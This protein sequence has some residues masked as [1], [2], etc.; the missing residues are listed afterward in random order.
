MRTHPAPE[1]GGFNPRAF[2]AFILCSAG[3]LLAMATFAADPPTGTLTPAN[4]TLTY[5]AGPFVQANQ[6]PLALGQLDP[7]PR[8]DNTT[9]PCDSYVL[10]VSLPAGYAATHPNAAARVTM[11]WTDTG[12]GQSDY[13][14]YIF[15][16]DVGDLDG[17]RQ[18]DYQSASGADPEVAY[19]GPIPDGQSKYTIKIVPY[20]PTGETVNVKIEFLPGNGD[21]GSPTFGSADPTKPGVPRY[22]NFY[23]PDGSSAESSQG[24]F[25]IGFN[26]HTGRMM[27]MNT[28]PIWRITPPEKQSPAKPECCEGLWEDVTAP[29][30]ETG[31]DPILWTDQVSGRTFASNSTV[32]TNGVYA[33]SDNDGDLWNPVTAAPPNASSDHETIGSGPYPA[34]VPL[35]NPANQG[36][37]VY[38]CAQTFPV[39]AAACQRSDTLGSDYGPS[40][41]PY[42]AHTSECSGIHGHVRVGPDGT[43]YLPVRDCGGNAG[44]AVSMDAGT[45]WTNYI[46]PNSKTQTH[47]SDPSVAIGANNTVYFF[48]VRDQ[49]PSAQD[50]IEGHIHVQVST[51]HGATWGKD[52]D[53]G[54]SHGIRNAVFPEAWAG[55][56]ARAAVGFLGTNRPGDYEGISFPGLWYAFIA[57]TFDSGTTWNIVNATPN[58]PVQGVGGIWQGGGSPHNRNLLDFN[59]ATADDKGRFLYGYSDGCVGNCVQD[60]VQN[61]FTAFMRVARQSGG[62][63]LFAA[64]DV[65]EPHPANPACLSGTRGRD[66]SHLTWIAPDNGGADI[67]SYQIFRGTT[68]NFNPVV[69]IAETGGGKT[70]YFDA[71]AD[72][73]VEHYFYVIK[74]INSTGIGQRSNTID[75]KVVPVPPLENVCSLAGITILTDNAGDS[76]LTPSS[77]GTDMLAAH[78]SQPFVQDGVLKFVFTMDTDPGTDTQPPGSGWFIAM[79][80]PDAQAQGGFRYTGVRMDGGTTPT[81]ASYTPGANTSGGVD[82]RFVDAEKP[83]EP[84]SHYDSANGKIVIVV[85]ASDLGLKPGDTIAGFVSGSSQSTDPGPIGAGATEVYDFMPDSGAFTGGYTVAPNAA[86]APNTPPV[87]VLTASPESGAA[88]LNVSFSG[89]GSSDADKA[90]KDTIVSYTFNF[91]DGSAP[92]TQSSPTISHTYKAAGA[93]A[94]QL[95]VKD[96]RGQE[97][98]N[99]AR[100]I[101]EVN[102]ALRNIS[103]RADVKT[104][105]NVLIGGFIISGNKSRTVVLRAIG[106]SLESGGNPVGGRMDDPLLELHAA[107]GGII[108]TN[109]NWKTNDQTHTSQEAQVRNTGLAP[110][111]N[112]ESVIVRTLPPGHYTAILRGKNNSTGIALVE[113]YDIDPA[114]TSKL[115]NISTRGLVETGDNVMI[116]GFVAGPE[117]AAPTDVLLRGLGPSLSDRHVANALQDPVLELRDSNGTMRASNDNWKSTQQAEIQATGVAPSRDKEAAILVGELPPGNYTVILSGKGGGTG[118]GLVE[119]YNVP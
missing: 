45:T 6:T 20:Q 67:K 82:G 106:P 100:A 70:T 64:N 91:G 61:S 76:L 62:K 115:V 74:A 77:N 93:Y 2:A 4:P 85:K 47:G 31:L 98:S 113:A 94:A 10:T 52:T 97:S 118:I 12:A 88:P 110:K 49:T 114:G 111:D 25:N 96:S 32:G 63:S 66:G 22:Q 112:R 68:A 69:P 58:D 40:T 39:G 54:A 53:L 75:L 18:A 87:A 60:P 9:F 17:S 99:V 65:A 117:D 24:E 119:V 11:G 46:I 78:L 81:F 34:S 33:Y 37:A 104:G 105:D 79:K 43:V 83:A 59:E 13:D 116:G 28:G 48:Y 92:V 101:I 51:D 57:T 21:A 95:T 73:S 1:A 7:G 84:Q 44:V 107:N 55:D 5:S 71:T 30:T 56:D 86:C 103:T 36:R 89:A 109:D 41:F 80:V 23:A 90:P 35:G 50:P 72:P 29:T 3:A 38:Y 102:A 108:T 16:G 8:C 15:K 19:I 27:L 42:D 14:L 26:P